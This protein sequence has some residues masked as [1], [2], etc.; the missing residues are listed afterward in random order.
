MRSNRSDGPRQTCFAV[1]GTYWRES[2]R[3]AKACFEYLV[4]YAQRGDLCLLR[5]AVYKLSV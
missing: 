4:A 3:W 1:A 5:L 2:S